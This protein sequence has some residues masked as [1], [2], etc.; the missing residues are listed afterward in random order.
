M[1]IKQRTRHWIPFEILAILF[2]ISLA[3]GKSVTPTSE[4][5]SA[6]T[7]NPASS[8]T[9]AFQRWTSNDVVEIFKSASLE[10]A[11]TRPMTKD[12]Y[13]MA[14]M[15]AIEGTH[16]V[17]PS[18][19]SN[20]GGRILSFSSQE[21]LEAT[22]TY[23]EDL[24]KNNAL[25]FSWVF[26]KDNI[27][28]QINGDLPE[29]KARQYESALNSLSSL[30]LEAT[31]INS[32]SPTATSK[33]TPTPQATP[34][35]Y[36]YIG[37]NWP[38]GIWDY[39]FKSDKGARGHLHLK[40]YMGEQKSNIFEIIGAADCSSMPSGQGYL[41]RYPNGNEEWKDRQAME[42]LE[43]FVLKDELQNTFIDFSWKFYECP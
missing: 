28:I 18:L 8:S 43:L 12:D 17:I 11:G 3:C 35:P 2:L 24:G 39:I 23:Y 9:S 29:G 34:D 6:P 4:V 5:T 27:L 37:G 20:C 19:C 36:V 25:F 40:V 26:V 42:N 31:P 38:N 16:F 22:K 15:R 30:S 10:V 41:V 33:Y 7:A 21:D 1:N 32:V 14:P 13:G